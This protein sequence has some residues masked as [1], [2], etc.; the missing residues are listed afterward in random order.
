[1]DRELRDVGR[2]PA[3]PGDA[4]EMRCVLARVAARA[5]E[6][7]RRE[8]ARRAEARGRGD[9]QG[10]M[11]VVDE[12]AAAVDG[13]ARGRGDDRLVLGRAGAAA[14]ARELVPAA[15]AAVVARPGQPDGGER[16]GGR[17]P[18]RG[19]DLE[20]VRGADVLA[21]A[22]DERGGRSGLRELE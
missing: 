17:E 8:G 14:D 10:L 11:R 4:E 5:L 9:D 1:D 7:V 18:A 3:A 19:D 12:L 13:R 2:R 6:A 15:R 22:V 21:C 16:P 20:L